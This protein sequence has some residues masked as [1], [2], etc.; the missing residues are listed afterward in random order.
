MMSAMISIVDGRTHLS[1]L[2]GIESGSQLMLG[3][4][5]IILSSLREGDWLELTEMLYLQG[6]WISPHVVEGA[7]VFQ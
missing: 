5:R 4:D 7:D 1:K 2:V 3:V 6:S